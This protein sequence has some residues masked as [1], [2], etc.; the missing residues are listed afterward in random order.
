M[1]EDSNNTVVLGALVSWLNCWQANSA[2]V[3]HYTKGL[4]GCGS[5]LEEGL[6]SAYFGMLQIIA[7]KLAETDDPQ[8]AGKLLKAFNCRFRAGEFQFL[9]QTIKIFPLLMRGRKSLD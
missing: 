8:L 7:D 9:S 3:L 1:E 4:Q 6:R 2:E 5:L